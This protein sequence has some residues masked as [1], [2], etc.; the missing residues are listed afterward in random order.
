M[1]ES[2]CHVAFSYPDTDDICCEALSPAKITDDIYLTV[3]G[4]IQNN[5]SCGE[6]HA[7]SWH[8]SFFIHIGL[9]NKL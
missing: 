4:T 2:L 9:S 7:I 3:S 8:C 6:P 1:S 5:Q